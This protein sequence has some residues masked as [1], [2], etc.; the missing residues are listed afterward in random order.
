MMDKSFEWAIRC[1]HEAKFWEHNAFITL[2]YADEHLPWHGSL[3]FKHLQN[4]IKRLR[5]KAEGVDRAPGSLERPIRYFA[6]G[7]YGETTK[8]AHYHVLLFNTK[9]EKERELGPETYT[10]RMLTDLWRYG[11]HVVGSVNEK[12]ISYVAGYCRKKV[13]GRLE[14]EREYEVVHPET[15]EVVVRQR[16]DNRMSRNPGIGKYWYDKYGKSDLANGYLVVDGKKCPV[17]RFYQDKFKEDFPLKYEDIEWSRSQIVR[18]PNERSFDR[19]QV[20]EAVA[21]GR[22]AFFKQSTEIL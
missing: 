6:C 17:P 2:T 10:S 4:F 9:F 20:K 19:L 14:S 5:W 12:S 7:E 21:R 22:R 15:G 8:R 3:D 11:N 18:D 16:V 1:R 13:Y